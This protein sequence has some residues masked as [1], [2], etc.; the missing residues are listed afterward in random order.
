MREEKMVKSGN[1]MNIPWSVKGVSK[2]AR[3]AAKKA[4]ALEGVT[5]GEWLR[6]AIRTAKTDPPVVSATQ[7]ARAILADMTLSASRDVVTSAGQTEALRRGICDRIAQSEV[8]ILGLVA[9]IQEIIQQLSS[10][11]ESLVSPPPPSSPGALPP[12]SVP[13]RPVRRK[14]GRD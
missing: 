11:V 5:M 10:R 8:P 9:P 6:R 2:E 1:K 7:T 4:A 13:P 14:T 12:V 3:A